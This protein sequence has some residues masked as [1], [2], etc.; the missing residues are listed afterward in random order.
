M[1]RY[2]RQPLPEVFAVSCCTQ[3]AARAAGGGRI[4]GLKAAARKG[5]GAGGGGM[6]DAQKN[7]TFAGQ[8]FS[9]S[10]YESLLPSRRVLKSPGKKYSPG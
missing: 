5:G 2:P 3:K 4:S 8:S 1:K 9:F 10:L 6:R 7:I